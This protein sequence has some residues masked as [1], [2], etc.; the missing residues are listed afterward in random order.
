[1]NTANII[2]FAKDQNII[3]NKSLKFSAYRDSFLE[4]KKWEKSVL[5]YGNMVRTWKNKEKFIE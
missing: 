5:R 4:K 3:R 2:K 1:M